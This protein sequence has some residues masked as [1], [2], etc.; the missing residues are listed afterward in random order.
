MASKKELPAKQR[1]ELLAI[2]QKRFEANAKLH[3]GIKWADV[4]KRL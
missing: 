3:R 2:L 1:D 4:E